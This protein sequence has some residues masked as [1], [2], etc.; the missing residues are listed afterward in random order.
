MAK[1]FDNSEDE[2]VYIAI[3]Y[4]SNDEGDKMELISHARKKWYMHYW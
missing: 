4:E 2:M 3:K 1:D